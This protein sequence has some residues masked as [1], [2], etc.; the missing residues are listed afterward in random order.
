[1]NTSG[2]GASSIALGPVLARIREFSLGVWS[3]DEG[4]AGKYMACLLMAT[5]GT[6]GCG[7]TCRGDVYGPVI[8]GTV[9]LAGVYWLLPDVRRRGPGLWVERFTFSSEIDG[10]FRCR[11]DG[12]SRRAESV[13]DGDPEAGTD[14]WKPEDGS[15]EWEPY[16]LREGGGRV[17]AA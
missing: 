6:I 14:D 13:L 10:R 9:S 11:V 16:E 2:V 15:N 5:A 12:R 8:S 7:T 17:T 3:G 1:M 4:S